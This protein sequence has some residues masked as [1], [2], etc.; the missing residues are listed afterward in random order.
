MV[1]TGRQ[2]GQTI[3]VGDPISIQVA[4]VDVE[5]GKVDFVRPFKKTKKKNQKPSRRPYK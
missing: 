4:G 3:Q 1:L 5:Q 2:T